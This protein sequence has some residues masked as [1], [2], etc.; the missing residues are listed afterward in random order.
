MR[1]AIPTRDGLK[2]TTDLGQAE[3]FLVITIQGGEMVSEELRKNRFNTYFDKGKGPLSLI[4]DC[5]I[6]LVNNVDIQFCELI[7]ENHM[8]CIATEENLITNAILHF[9]EH[10]YKSESNTCCCP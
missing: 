7:R 9:L 1:I 6:V 4:E 5:T 3:A 2:I 8:E 10:E